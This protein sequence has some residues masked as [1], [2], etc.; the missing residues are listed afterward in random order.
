MEF[1]LGDVRSLPFAE[2]EF[3]F[4]ID[5]GTWYHISRPQEAIE[6]I[7]RVLEPGGVF[8]YETRASQ[9]LSHPMRLIRQVAALARDCQPEAHQATVL[10]G[11]PRQAHPG[12]IR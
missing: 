10:V 4:V 7:S 11:Q 6:E 5:F 2:G 9:L 12:L 1:V 3:D 8:C